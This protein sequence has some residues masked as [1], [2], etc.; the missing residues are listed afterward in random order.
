LFDG[1]VKEVFVSPSTA[2]NS[3]ATIAVTLPTSVNT[4][5][6]WERLWGTAG[7]QFVGFFIITSILFGNQPGVGASSDALAAFYTGDRTRILIAAVFSGLNILNL[8]W[9]AA[10]LRATLAEAKQDGWGTAVTASSAAF[11]GLYLL[12]VSIVATLAYSIA[13]AGN[14]TLTAGLNDLTWILVALSS[15]PRA[16]LIMAGTFGFWRAG[17]ISNALFSAGVAAVVLG[18]LGGTTL[19]GSG[20]WAPD[21]AYPRFV[22]PAIGLVW[23]VVVS[24][25]L[26]SRSPATRASW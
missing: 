20:P 7:I 19:L 1:T 21:G 16:M 13:G 12:L 15:F 14:S 8:M 22:S 10:A 9:F 17:L 11:G 18:V 24:R 5:A 4:P 3:A 25:V 2:A 6:F 26:L 23:I